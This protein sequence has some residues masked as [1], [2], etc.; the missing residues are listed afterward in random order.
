LS[1]RGRVVC[2]RR[3]CCALVGAAW[4]RPRVRVS[5]R[6]VERVLRSGGNRAVVGHAR[7]KRIVKAFVC[8][9]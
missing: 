5:Y 3:S 6:Q 7:M 2:S 4:T 1:R 8:G 9:W